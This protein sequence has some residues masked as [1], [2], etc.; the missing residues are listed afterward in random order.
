M[1]AAARGV[2]VFGYDETFLLYGKGELRK[3]PA[4]A[5]LAERLASRY[6][7]RMDSGLFEELR[8]VFLTL[9]DLQAELK[10]ARETNREMEKKILVKEDEIARLCSVKVP[11]RVA[12]SRYQKRT[13]GMR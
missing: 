12:R 3:S 7:G 5:G 8:E 6:A 1:L 11:A 2:K 13:P 4:K 9:E 10:E